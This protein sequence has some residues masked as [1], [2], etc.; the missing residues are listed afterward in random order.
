MQQETHSLNFFLTLTSLKN[1]FLGRYL[2]HVN[3]FFRIGC[4]RGSRRLGGSVLIKLSA[5]VLGSV[6]FWKSSFQLKIF[7]KERSKGAFALCVSVGGNGAY[8]LPY[9]PLKCLSC[10]WDSHTTWN[11]TRPFAEEGFAGGW[12]RCIFLSV[13]WA[14]SPGFSQPP[15]ITFPIFIYLEIYYSSCHSAKKSG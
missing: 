10:Q 3:S 8:L 2:S 5:V 15:F 13:T 11:S 7:L 12:V 14:V 4:N 6:T 1:V 9:I